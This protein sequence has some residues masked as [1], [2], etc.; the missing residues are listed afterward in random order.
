[1]EKR[2]FADSCFVRILENVRATHVFL[3]FP[4]EII[5]STNNTIIPISTAHFTN[6]VGI[7]FAVSV[8]NSIKMKCAANN[9]VR[10]CLIASN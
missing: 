5:D 8:I 6:D 2:R 3:A 7:L 10:K 4:R 1:M 9:F